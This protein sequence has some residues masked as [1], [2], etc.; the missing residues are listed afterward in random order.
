M[1]IKGSQYDQQTYVLNMNMSGSH[2]LVEATTNRRVLLNALG[3]QVK[4]SSNQVCGNNA[5][6]V[7]SRR[8]KMKI[9]AIT[10]FNVRIT[11]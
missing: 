11:V 10:V 9:T 2:S 5:K 1:M 3:S 6:E 8:K 7:I 4:E